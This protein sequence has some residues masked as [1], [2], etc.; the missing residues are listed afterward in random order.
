MTVRHKEV[1]SEAALGFGAEL[2]AA[3]T[4]VGWTIRDLAEAIR[5]EPH[6]VNSVKIGEFEH[7][8]RV[9]TK[10]EARL[11]M[12][13]LGFT[14]AVVTTLY[15]SAAPTPAMIPKEIFIPVSGEGLPEGMVAFCNEVPALRHALAHGLRDVARVRL[16]G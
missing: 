11:L 10:E 6:W 1:V 12:Q 2:R 5:G 8:Y 14:S 3:R 16:V 9:P 7:G 13:S 15:V 4:A